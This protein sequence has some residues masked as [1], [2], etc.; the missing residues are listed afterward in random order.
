M[1]IKTIQL[2]SS[3]EV[4]HFHSK[5]EHQRVLEVATAKQV[6]KLKVGIKTVLRNSSQKVKPNLKTK[7]FD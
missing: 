2:S 1:N 5:R 4:D 6:N 7:T 3:P